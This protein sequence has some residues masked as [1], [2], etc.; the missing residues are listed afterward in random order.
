MPSERNDKSPPD[1]SNASANAAIADAP[2]PR[3]VAIFAAGLGLRTSF[4]PEGRGLLIEALSTTTA[5]ALYM[6]RRGVAGLGLRAPFTQEGRL[7][8][9]IASSISITLLTIYNRVRRQPLLRLTS[10]AVVWGFVPHVF[11]QEWE[12][13]EKIAP[14]RG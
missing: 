8:I 11:W 12:L 2:L 5:T 14:L 4:T 13:R 7:R 6:A 1:G 10:D 9:L 3:P